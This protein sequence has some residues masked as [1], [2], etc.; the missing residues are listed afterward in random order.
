MPETDNTSCMEAK[1]YVDTPAEDV[2][3]G[4]RAS[5]GVPQ[6]REDGSV[7]ETNESKAGHVVC[8]EN[9]PDETNQESME[10]H[11]EGV[12]K[13]G[14][15]ANKQEKEPWVEENIRTTEVQDLNE[16]REAS[17]F[18]TTTDPPTSRSNQ[19]DE[20]PLEKFE[21]PGTS[22]CYQDLIN[23]STAVEMSCTRREEVSPSS[24][25]ES[26]MELEAGGCLFTIPVEEKGIASFLDSCQEALA[27]DFEVIRLNKTDQVRVEHQE[28]TS[29]AAK[30]RMRLRS[31]GGQECSVS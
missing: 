3:S 22:K 6:V 4:A 30:H 8:V 1:S 28:D 20:E 11:H 14:K 16:A 7:P 17:Q 23:P 25:Q 10:A 26:E 13:V 24:E 21:L 15:C 19:A 5:G 18:I 9:A 29:P 27:L 12:V 2:D 31:K